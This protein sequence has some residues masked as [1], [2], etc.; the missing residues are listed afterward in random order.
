EGVLHSEDAFFVYNMLIIQC[1]SKIFAEINPP[2]TS[3]QIQAQN[4][5]TTIAAKSPPAALTMFVIFALPL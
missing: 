4:S 3:P 5:T 1:H 2:R